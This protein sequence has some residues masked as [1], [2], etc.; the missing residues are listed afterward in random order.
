MYLSGVGRVT[1]TALRLEKA[2]TF[3]SVLDQW[4]QLSGS[5]TNVFST[6][7]WAQLWWAHFGRDR[8][9]LIWT[10]HS[11]DD[12]LGLVPLYLWRRAPLRIVRL[13]GHGQADALEPIC[14]LD[15]ELEVGGAMTEILEESAARL[16]IAD[17][18]PGD[19][20]WERRL[21]GRIVRREAS[22]CLRW[23]SGWNEFVRSRSANLR[24]QLRRRER[25]L[26][27]E[28]SVRFRL[29]DNPESLA[30]DLDVLFR[31][32][33][34]V[35][36]RTDFQPESFHREFAAI[37][38]ERGWLR[39]WVLELDDRPAAAWYGFRLG[40]VE[41]YYQ[42]GRDPSLDHLSVGFVLLVHSIRSALED[43]MTE[44]RFG[45]GDEPYKYRF[46][47]EDYGVQ[48]LA[49][50]RGVAMPGVILALATGRRAARLVRR[51]S[52]RTRSY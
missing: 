17:Q 12:L 40:G 7:E 41:T 16:F 35:H 25:R 50:A 33:N 2:S 27:D 34:S 28:Y 46:A 1:V 38:L 5:A 20:A 31:L 47:N 11:G 3:D 32:H 23:T 52:A 13:V 14:V 4:R 10:V 39:L 49:V 51:P 19:S 18:L 26:R 24:E 6:P 43:G 44:Y 42:A 36:P 37:A 45:R 21:G 30:R 29:T 15:R 22:P 48:T 8:P 9:L